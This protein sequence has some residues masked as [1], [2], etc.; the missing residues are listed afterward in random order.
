MFILGLDSSAKAASCAIFD[1]DNRSITAYGGINAGITHSETLMPLVESILKAAKLTLNDIGALAVTNGPGSF[2]GVRI[3]VSVVK[4]MAFALELPVYAVSAL[5]S[6]AYN[7]YGQDCIVCAVMDARRGQFYN[8]LFR[9]KNNEAVRLTED[10][11]IGGNELKMELQAFVNEKIIVAGDGA[12]LFCKESDYMCAPLQQVHQN[13][14]SVCLAALN[15][16]PVTSKELMPLYLRL[17]QAE[18]ERNEK[19]T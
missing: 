6:L 18:R 7:L 14:V 15:E 11:A 8:A 16:K 5:H 1:S 3:A 10:R 17:P 4:G 19:I 13:A 9:V 2:T 12:Q